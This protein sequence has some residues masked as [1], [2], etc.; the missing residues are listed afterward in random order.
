MDARPN[1]YAVE[2]L[3]I[4][5]DRRHLSRHGREIRLG[6]L[7]FDLLVLLVEG[8]PEVI[9]AVVLMN[10]LWP[11]SE[12]DRDTLTQ[13]VIALRAALGDDARTPR[14]IASVRGCGYRIIAQVHPIVRAD[15]NAGPVRL[16]AVLRAR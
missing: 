6:R 9:S 11:D 2:D 15:Q 7:T 3:L 5:L 8:A 1:R 12:I 16:R 10:Q 13:R 4:E 14:Y